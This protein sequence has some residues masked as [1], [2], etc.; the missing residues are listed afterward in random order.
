MV[1]AHEQAPEQ[2]TS[3]GAQRRPHETTPGLPRLPA[4][5]RGPDPQALLA[6]QRMVGNVALTRYLDGLHEHERL[7]AG[8]RAVQPSGVTHEL[9]G[10][11]AGIYAGDGLR[12]GDSP[13]RVERE[14]EPSPA[15]ATPAPSPI[16]RLP[17]QQSV[18]GSFSAIQR[19]M[20]VAES[21]TP[22]AD[23]AMGPSFRG[24]HAP[25]EFN[26][27][28]AVQIHE[29]RGNYRANTIIAMSIDQAREEI[30]GH[31]LGLDDQESIGLESEGEIEFTTAQ[32]YPF[33]ETRLDAEGRPGLHRA[34]NGR[35]HV[36]AR[37]NER[38]HC[39]Q[40]YHLDGA[41]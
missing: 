28:A 41:E 19:T 14:T 39:F 2:S 24:N 30:E 3:A 18:A 11:A 26:V 1:H 37:W 29:N 15:P 17:D 31:L 20:D 9:S 40:L 6:L 8:T 23:M 10:P 21:Y 32:R 25:D 12:A 36:R 33:I 22:T 16:Q 7:D 5:A 4:A 34:E 38:G 27:E 35:V 13:N